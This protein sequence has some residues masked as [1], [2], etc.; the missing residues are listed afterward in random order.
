MGGD[1]GGIREERGRE[2]RRGERKRVERGRGNGLELR[3]EKVEMG[4]IGWFGVERR[5]G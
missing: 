2:E 4:E 1:G 5:K 3:E